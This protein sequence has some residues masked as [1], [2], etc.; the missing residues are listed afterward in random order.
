[1][2]HNTGTLGMTACSLFRAAI[3][4]EIMAVPCCPITVNMFMAA[5]VSAAADT[6]YALPLAQAFAT[7]ACLCQRKCI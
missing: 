4:D 3:F 1:M 2:R 7:R 6:T 5:M